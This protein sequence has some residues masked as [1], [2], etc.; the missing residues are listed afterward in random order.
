MPKTK[1]RAKLVK[2]LEASIANISLFL[3][4]CNEEKII[5]RMLQS[6]L[7]LRPFLCAMVVVHNSTDKTIELMQDW[8]RIQQLPFHCKYHEFNNFS[9]QRQLSLDFSKE[10]VAT[11]K[12]DMTI[13]ADHSI[14]IV[15]LNKFIREL[16]SADILSIKEIVSGGIK[17]NFNRRIFS[18]RV[19]CQCWG[20]THEIWLSENCTC[21]YAKVSGI[22]IIDNYD[23]AS[24]IVK[25]VRDRDLL[26]QELQILSINPEKNTYFYELCLSRAHFYLANTYMALQQYDNAIEHFNIRS[27]LGGFE[28]EIYISYW[29]IGICYQKLA[30]I[31]S[32][33]L[34]VTLNGVLTDRVARLIKQHNV[35]IT[36]YSDILQQ[37]T[38]YFQ[39]AIKFYHKAQIYRPTRAEALYDMVILFR[40]LQQSYDVVSLCEQARAIVK[41]KDIFLVNNEIYRYLFDFEMSNVAHYCPETNLKN[42]AQAATRRLE[43]R[44][45]VL[46]LSAFH[47]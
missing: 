14:N 18:R 5:N 1:K 15:N 20:A 17:E 32:Q 30:A 8:C 31:Y 41:P 26:L 46:Q 35:T 4:C 36:T 24:H 38:A 10:K 23:G 13:D 34:P 28:E 40:S 19:D 47:Y 21:T 7:P 44:N 16:D 22:Q 42:I 43:K 27:T 3:I 2:K 25:Y 39:Q 45:K 33:I 6:L 11:A 29:N 37:T 12:Y 9:E